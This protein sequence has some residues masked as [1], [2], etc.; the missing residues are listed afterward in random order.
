MKGIDIDI[1]EY[2]KLKSLGSSSIKKLLKNPHEFLNPKEYKET[3]ATQIGSLVHCMVLEPLEV[4]KRYIP[5]PKIDKRTKEGKEKYQIFLEQKEARIAIP[6]DDYILAKEISENFMSQNIYKKLFKNGVA[7]KSYFK[8]ID[9]VKVKCRP[10]YYN[11]KLKVIIDLKTTDDCS[12]V[13]F[14]RQVIN[15][16]YNIQSSFYKDILE[17]DRFIFIVL[18]KTKPYMIGV[19]E[20]CKYDDAMGRELY[21]RGLE[22]YKKL[23]LYKDP[24]YKTIDNELIHK[25]ELPKYYYNDK[26]MM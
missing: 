21:K 12:P 25:I 8:E 5:I 1:E 9:G 10:D 13:A 2:H 18:S 15:Y 20:L 7:E 22:V 23:S 4:E 16:D 26:G 17:A 14:K 24:I 6:E 19:Y 3:K 11:E